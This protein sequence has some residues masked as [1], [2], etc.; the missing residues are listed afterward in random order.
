M[1]EHRLMTQPQ[2]IGLAAN[3][4]SQRTFTIFVVMALITTFAST[5]LA[6][7]LYPPWYQ[8]KLAAWKRGEI[9][10]DTGAPIQ[11]TD[12]PNGAAAAE[13]KVAADRVGRLLVYL[14]LDNLPAVLGLI[15]LFGNPHLGENPTDL[16]NEASGSGKG[17]ATESEQPPKRPVRAHGMRLLQLTDRD[18][19]FMTV[20]QVNDYSKHDPVVNT[21]CTVGQLHHLS[22]SGEVSIMPETRFSEALLAKSSSAPSDLLLVPWSETGNMGDS[23]ILSSSTA[24]DKL[25]VPYSEFVRSILRSAEQNVAV[26]FA[27]SD[28]A[29]PA[30]E[31]SERAK[32]ARMY[33]FSAAEHDTPALPPS[34]RSSHIFLAYLG[35]RDDRLALGLV[36]QLCERP[37]VTATIARFSTGGDQAA[38]AVDDEFLSAMMAQAAPDVLARVKS[39]VVKGVS[40]V[41]DVLASAAGDLNADPRDSARRDIIVVGRRAG[42]RVDAGKL[43][44]AGET[45]RCL[46]DVAAQIVAAGVQGDLLVVQAKQA[47]A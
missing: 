18:S 37:E 45:S 11:G 7:V 34:H 4:I 10:W 29:P 27:Q 16:S 20:A 35:G 13:S 2:N 43:P 25:T 46:G 3:I 26:F 5:P 17:T 12:G 9:D 6:T 15:S 24:K 44:S 22:I 33:S 42:A 14:R 32:L 41:E 8:K 23:Q 21:F 19:S 30:S 39:E 36:L 40:T 1:T 38:A 28:A 47:G 31:T